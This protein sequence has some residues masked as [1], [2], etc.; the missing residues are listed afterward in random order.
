MSFKTLLWKEY[1]Q[2]RQVLVASVLLLLIPYVVVTTY[3]LVH[4]LRFGEVYEGSWANHILQASGY[5]LL[6]SVLLCSFISGNAIAGERADR[7][8]EFLGYLPISRISSV[9]VKAVFAASICMVMLFTNGLVVYLASELLVDVTFSHPSLS[10]LAIFCVVVA[11][12]MFGVSWLVSAIMN[13]PAIAA[14]SGLASVVILG[15]ILSVVEDALGHQGRTSTRLIA[16]LF[17]GVGSACFIAG[18]VCYLRRI[19]P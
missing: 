16:T 15:M 8:A 2:S 3:G 7:S 17:G 6:L 14:V 5:S 11:I 18:V 9:A 19:E 1:R 12:L 13:R 10:T 4:I